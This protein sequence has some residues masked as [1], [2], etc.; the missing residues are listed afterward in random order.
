MGSLNRVMLIGNLGR[1]AEL[2]TTPRGDDVASWSMACSETWT[3]RNGEKH[4]KTEWVR[5]VLWGKRASALA[6]YLTKGKQI[7]VEGKLTTREW[8]KDGVKRYSTEVNAQDIVLL[9]SGGGGGGS[10]G[11]ARRSSER[12]VDRPDDIE[13]DGSEADPMGSPEPVDMPEDDIPF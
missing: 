12:R 8:E 2:R 5:V 1:D 6:Q 4:E 10:R 11:S 13:T 3:D 7:F 9:G